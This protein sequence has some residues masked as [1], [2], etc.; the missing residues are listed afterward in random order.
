MPEQKTIEV[1]TGEVQSTS[2]SETLQSGVIGSSLAVIVYDRK[3]GNGGIAHIMLPGQSPTKKTTPDTKYA[4]DAIEELL[5]QMKNLG[6][7]P[8]NMLVF[9]VGAGNVLRRH[10]DVVCLE[11][12]KSTTKILKSSRMTVAKRAMGGF[13]RRR[14]RIDTRKG[15]VYY[16]E[17]DGGER[18][19]WKKSKW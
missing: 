11:N 4:D 8:K 18:I 15:I 5:K 19:L 7:A 14:A 2:S 1:A 16:C 17:G 12:V 3:K 9:L 6:S 10:D 13:E